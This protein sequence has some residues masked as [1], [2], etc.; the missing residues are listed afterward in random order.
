MKSR[1]RVEMALNHEQPDR[2]PFQAGFTPEF[3]A[4]LLGEKGV[5]D[6]KAQNPLEGGNSHTIERA[7]GEDIL[8]TSV[9]WANSYYLDSKPY[10]DEWGIEWNIIPYET[11]F[12]TGAYTEICNHPLSDNQAISSYQA[13]DPNRPELY[14]AGEQMVRD[15]KDEYWI[16]GSTAATIFETAWALR[17]S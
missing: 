14:L 12:G 17:V 9:G 10:T 11:A 5:Q 16:V 4:R 1:E 15:F 8:I 13:P 6:L 7:L 3:A 2:C